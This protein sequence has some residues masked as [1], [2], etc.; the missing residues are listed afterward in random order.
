VTKAHIGHTGSFEDQASLLEACS[1]D[2]KA[3]QQANSLD[4]VI[5]QVERGDVAEIRKQY[6]PQGQC[7]GGKPEWKSLKVTVNKRERIYKQLMNEFNGDKDQFF[8]FFTI[9]NLE[10]EASRRKGK[11]K[12]AEAECQLM[13]SN[14]VAEA[15]PHRDKDLDEEM[16]SAAY[17][18]EQGGFSQDLWDARWRGQNRWEIWRSLGKE[19]Y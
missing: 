17:Q 12:R 19:K 15:I 6:G 4:E 7:K 3:L 14:K 5:A 1:Y 13:A 11:R 9:G 8:R 16:A 10:G 18:D 2:I